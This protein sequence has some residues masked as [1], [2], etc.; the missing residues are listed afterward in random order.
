M[1]EPIYFHYKRLDHF[2]K[3]LDEI[4]QTNIDILESDYDK[5]VSACVNISPVTPVHIRKILKTLY[6]NKYYEYTP[7]ICNAINGTPL[8]LPIITPSLKTI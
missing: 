1:S 8:L 4:N 7:Y 5:I 3:W 2:N 6:L